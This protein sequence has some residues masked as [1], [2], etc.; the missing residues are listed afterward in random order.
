MPPSTRNV[1]AVMKLD[2]SL[3]RNS[4]G[5]GDLVGVGEAAHRDVH[6]PP[7][8]PLR[9]L[10][11]QLAQ[12]RGVDR[13]GAQRVDPDALAGELHAELAA[14]REHAALARGVGDLRRRGA[15]HGDERRGVDDRA[16]ALRAHVG[17]HGLAAQV[18]AGEVDLLHPA[19]GVEPGVEDRVVVGRG[20]AGVVEGDVD[21]AVRLVGLRRPSPS[22]CSGVGHVAAHVEPADLLGC[23]A[24]A[25]VVE[26]GDAR[27]RAPSS[28]NRRDGRQ[29]DAAAAAGDDRGAVLAADALPSAQSSV[30]MKTFL[31]SVNESSASGPSSRPRPDCL[32]PPNGVE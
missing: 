1:D 2:S 29:P 21:A 10:G 28:A 13:P 26:V 19:P 17:Q 18:D 9:V 30:L 14:H 11:E 31:T 16:P 15:H 32:K 20:D 24:A 6:Q 22:T 12:Q 23:G 27:P 3:A 8:R 4:D 25:F 5:V 7:G